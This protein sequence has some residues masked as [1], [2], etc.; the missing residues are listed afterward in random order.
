MRELNEVL[1]DQGELLDEIAD[2]LPALR[3]KLHS[4]RP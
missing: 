4:N 2:E 3:L 1:D